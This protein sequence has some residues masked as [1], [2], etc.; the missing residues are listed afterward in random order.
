MLSPSPQ[1]PPPVAIRMCH[2][3]HVTLAVGPVS[4]HLTED[5]FLAIAAAVTAAADLVAARRPVAGTPRTAH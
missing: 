3:G 4:L 1:T 2:V 5:E